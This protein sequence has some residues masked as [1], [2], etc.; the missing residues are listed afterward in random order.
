MFRTLCPKPHSCRNRYFISSKS[1]SGRLAEAKQ[2]QGNKYEFPGGKVEQGEL[3][4]EACRREVI[5]EVG[6][7]IEQWQAFDFI[8]HEYEDVIV[9]LHIFHASVQP[10]QL[11]G[12]K[13]PW[14]WYSRDELSEL[15]F[16]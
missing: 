9:N 3:P 11:A 13:Q 15:N 1:G 5:E 7:D 8:S 4:V 14:R 6:I 16:S 10:E 2:H 12:I